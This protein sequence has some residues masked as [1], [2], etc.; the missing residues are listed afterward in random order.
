LFLLA[1]I[2][3]HIVYSPNPMVELSP[4]PAWWAAP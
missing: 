3:V 1:G 4:T 2:R